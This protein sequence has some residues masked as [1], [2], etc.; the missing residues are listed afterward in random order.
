MAWPGDGF[1][2]CSSCEPV[3]W[4]QGVSAWPS[5]LLHLLALVVI[6]GS[7][8][9]AW[10]HGVRT[11][12]QDSRWLAMEGGSAAQPR[13]PGGWLACLPRISVLRWP[14]PAGYSCDIGSLWREYLLRGAGRP[15]ATTGF[16]ASGPRARVRKRS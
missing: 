11:L 14:R 12:G 5:H 16:H 6:I 7:I 4:L 2:L 1:E 15:R 8:D 3:A 9:M 10:E 13:Q